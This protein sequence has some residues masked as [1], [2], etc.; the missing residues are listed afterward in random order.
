MIQYDDSA[1]ETVGYTLEVTN[2]PDKPDEPK[3]PQTG[4]DYK[5]W[6]FILLGGLFLGAGI[7][8]FIRGRKRK[9]G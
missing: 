2:K 4:G 1:T 7:I 9:R 5:T 8:G 3:L 6:R